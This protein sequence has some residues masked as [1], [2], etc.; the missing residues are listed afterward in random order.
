MS[1]MEQM[2]TRTR[3]LIGAVERLPVQGREKVL[4]YA[5]GLLD[6]YTLRQN[7]ERTN[8]PDRAAVRPGA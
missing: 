5:N 8:V 1:T 2:R 6:G 3:S 4:I 7:E